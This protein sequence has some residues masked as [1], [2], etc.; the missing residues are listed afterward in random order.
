MR[1]TRSTCQTVRMRGVLC[2]VQRRRRHFCSAGPTAPVEIS[3]ASCESSLHVLSRHWKRRRH[4]CGRWRSAARPSAH[5][6][7]SSARGPN[8]RPGHGAPR[9]SARSS[10]PETRRA[11]R[12]AT[13]NLQRW[14]PWI[15]SSRRPRTR[16]PRL[17]KRRS[18]HRRSR[19]GARGRNAPRV[20]SPSAAP[21][22][23]ERASRRNA[24]A[25][26]PR[27]SRTNRGR[28]E[29]TS[30]FVSVWAIGMT[31]CF[32]HTGTGHRSRRCTTSRRYNPRRR[33]RWCGAT[34]Q[35]SPPTYSRTSSREAAAE[36][37]SYDS[38][39]STTRWYTT[40]NGSGW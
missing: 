20:R 3:S 15:T 36:T 24:G 32:V 5:P 19:W 8:A 29:F 22:P 1:D 21:H 9:G 23:T 40:P 34:W 16:H 6:R 17:I 13:K 27:V 18:K 14:T 38:R 7:G 25:R 2:R 30:I 31:P 10:T 12:M 33:T 4:A 26:P 35:P 28:G 37:S 39:S 11:I